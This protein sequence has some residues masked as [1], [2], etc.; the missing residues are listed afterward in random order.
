MNRTKVI[1][2]RGCQTTH[3]FRSVDQRFIILMVLLTGLVL[4]L[5]FIGVLW[6][7]VRRKYRLSKEANIIVLNNE[8]YN[9]QEE[10][11]Y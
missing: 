11:K 2:C 1:I 3:G 4:G 8:S 5:G 6:Y 7:Y 9:P 10:S